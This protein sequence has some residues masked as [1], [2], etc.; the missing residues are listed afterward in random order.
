MALM[1][2]IR[3][4]LAMMFA[5]LAFLFVL[6]IVFEW[7]MDLSGGTGQFGTRPDVIGEVNGQDIKYRTF[8]EMV[9]QASESRK[10]Q[11]GQDLDEQ[12]ERMLRAQIW[13]QVV[14]DILV[15]H[16]IERLGITVTDQ[17][18]RDIVQGPNPPDFLVSQ[19][20][21]ST[22]TFQREAYLQAMMNPQNRDAWLQV[23]DLLRE[24]QKRVKLQSLLLAS[25]QVTEDEVL[26]RFID[27]S[28]TLEAQY[29][30]FDI[31]RMVPD[32][33]VTVTDEDLRRVYEDRPEEFKSMAT[34]KLKYVSFSLL[35]TQ[36]DSLA[37]QQD[38][39][40]LLGQIS[41]GISFGELAQTYSEKTQTDAFFR[42]GEL[43]RAKE[44]AI[45]AARKGDVVGP[46]RDTDGMHLIKILD[47]RKGSQ[48]YVNAAHILL[49]HKP[50]P[51][52]MSVIRTI[53]DLAR[54]ARAGADFAE[55]ARQHSE[56]GSAAN[57]GE[58]GWTGRGGWV[59]PFEDA[60]FGGRVGSIVG[61][62]RTQFGWHVIKVLGKDDR[63]LQ[64]SMISMAIKAGSQT[65]EYAYRTADDFS[66]LASE[67]GFEQAAEQNGFRVT[68]TPEFTR[69][70][71]VPGIGQN[72]I[73]TAFAFGNDVGDISDPTSIT[74]AVA[75][76]MVSG[77][78]DE[79][80]RPY[81]EVVA[82]LRTITFRNKRMKVVREMAE[83]FV[84]DI[85]PE[86]D[87]QQAATASD[88]RIQV[89]LTGPFKPGDV[90][91]GVGR[92][93]RFI[94]TALSLSPGEIA[95]PFEGIRGYYIMKLLSRTPVD[96]TAFATERPV[97]RSTLL[98]EKQSRF[99]SEWQSS[100]RER[101]D[102]RDYRYRFYR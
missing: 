56:D 52:S 40:H 99:L 16:E 11:T 97:L 9:R 20:T 65:V 61:P 101:A 44:S 90:P 75:V 98:R 74:N 63:E 82:T 73:V 72:D 43:S 53:R 54:Q 15:N 2:Q 29:A 55:L 58:L 39:E 93:P 62:V 23:E 76:F 48:T 42:H 69:D 49:R 100:L 4:N 8:T 27:R 70:G 46:I 28:V 7:G 30:L 78:R 1:S 85:S 59:K 32:T 68:E 12:G 80:V 35:P 26:R 18:I 87:L 25:V 45:F 91:T 13:D 57:G 86:T 31:N 89:S 17:E 5:V 51:D 41:G 6:M 84:K 81:D 94:G 19:F 66:Y 21:D 92:D 33:M 34:R 14:N 79:G 10:A 22:G 67:E 102:I 64:I 38:L 83:T 71:F 24:Q 37:I 50:G 36:E 77:A 96:S 95:K 3:K 47:E 60:A 88:P